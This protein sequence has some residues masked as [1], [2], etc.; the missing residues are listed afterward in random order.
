[1]PHAAHG[2]GKQANR[3]PRHARRAQ[4]AAPGT[5]RRL[6]ID[7]LRARLAGHRESCRD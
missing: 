4:T 5:R 7:R 3:S 2:P 6:P 1:M